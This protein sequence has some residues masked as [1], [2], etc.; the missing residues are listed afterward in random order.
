MNNSEKLHELKAQLEA[1]MEKWQTRIDE[2]K[3]Q[4]NLVGMEAAEKLG[5]HID[6]MEQEFYRAKNKLDDLETA[7][8]KSWADVKS[9][10]DLS[11]EAMKEAF[12]NVKKHFDSDK[13]G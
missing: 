7:S 8:E 13:A 12:A 9:G 10:L 3:V 2:A 5:P 4:A 1:E 6:S 11:V